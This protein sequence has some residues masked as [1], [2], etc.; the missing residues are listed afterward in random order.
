[1]NYRSVIRNLTAFLF[2]FLILITGTLFVCPPVFAEEEMM[3]IDATYYSVTDTTVKTIQVPFSDSWFTES[4][5]HYNHKLAQASL[6]FT[7]ASFRTSTADKSTPYSDGHAIE[8]LNQAGFSDIRTNDYDRTPG[9]YTIASVMGHKEI[10]EGNHSF[11]LIAIGISGQGYRDE[12]LSN[13]AVGDQ[14][15]HVGFTDAADDMYD[16][17]FGYIAEKRLNGK[18]LKVWVV[19][20]SRSAAVTNILAAKLTDTDW[21][22]SDDVYAYSF[23]TPRTTKNPKEGS[24]PNI[25]SIVG[26]MDPVPMVPFLNW[27]YTRYGTTFFTPSQETDSAYMVKKQN[28]E[29]VYEKLTGLSFWNNPEINNTLRLVAQYLMEI[30]PNSKIYTNYLEAQLLDIWQDRSLLNILRKLFDLSEDE[31]LINDE[32]RAEA[33]ELLDFVSS[34]LLMAATGVETFGFWEERATTSANI[35]HEHTPD[36]YVSWL[37]SSDDPED[38]YCDN[39]YYTIFYLDQPAEITVSEGYRDVFI[40]HADGTGESVDPNISFYVKNSPEFFAVTVPGDRP[41]SLAVSSADAKELL[42]QRLC[43]NTE[44][45]DYQVHDSAM[46]QLSANETRQIVDQGNWEAGTLSSNV[47][48]DGTEAD[49]LNQRHTTIQDLNVWNFSWRDLVLTVIT[50][51]VIC[52]GIALF[53]GSSLFQILRT[54]LG[55]HAGI[56]PKGTKAHLFPSLAFIM[57]I[58]LYLLMEFFAALYPDSVDMRTTF[59]LPI[60]CLLISVA[61]YAYL[62]V[63]SDL[64]LFTYMGVTLCSS[65]DIVI[66]HNMYVG[67]MLHLAGI[68]V[69]AYGFYRFEKPV[70]LQWIGAAAGALIGSY[71]IYR[72]GREYGMEC[73]LAIVYYCALVVMLLLSLRAPK[74]FRHGAELL[75]IAGVLEIYYEVFFPDVFTDILLHMLMIGLFYLGLITMIRGVLKVID[76]PVETVYESVPAPEVKTENA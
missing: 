4:A 46:V 39:G 64:H 14:E 11:E 23:G 31:N 20:Y 57:V 55:V 42:V 56:L 49:T 17:F 3:T 44:H 32:N 58:S 29:K 38:I 15:R 45:F 13:L 69:F 72:S 7:V 18:E 52:A 16:R 43:L 34:T 5:S 27:G 1:M 41:Y 74:R 47:V 6:G 53:L 48:T 33:N 36:I 8:F 59:K 40:L 22:S 67:A 30:V 61:W 26:T 25:F 71:V 37:L 24:Y 35:V 2:T 9:R 60:G 54:G 68:L 63:P 62:T 66:N 51:G 21:F 76:V 10:R 28:V 73:V 50:I 75:L 70:T 65:G 12:W 19:G